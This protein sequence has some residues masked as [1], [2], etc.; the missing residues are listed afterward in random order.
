MN[1]QFSLLVKPASY[2]CNLRCAYCFYL[3]K[4]SMFGSGALR[5]PRDTLRTLTR[6]YLACPMADHSFGWQGGEPTLMGLDFFREAVRL[7]REFLPDRFTSNSLQTNGTLLDDEWAVFLKENR[8]LT[9]ISIDGPRELH[10]RF[11]RD[12]SGAGTHERVLRGRAALE[13]AGAEYNV[14]TLVSA[15]NQDYPAEVYEYLKS[16]GVRY[17]QYIE[18]VEFDAAGKRAPF[19]LGP[20][21]WGEFLCGIF[22]AW[23]PK[24]VGKVS[25]RLFDSVVSRLVSGVPTM[26]SMGADCRHYLVVEHNG[27]IF[28]CDFFVRSDL[29]LGNILK[30]DFEQLRGSAGYRDWGGI[31]RPQTPE[32]FGCAWYA[33]CAGDCPKNRCGGM[34]ALCEDWKI[35]YSHTIERFERLA[36]Y[37]SGLSASGVGRG[38]REKPGRNDPCPCGSG[39]KYKNCCGAV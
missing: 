14:L 24:D 32:C 17:H 10:D 28:P 15:A 2:N 4:E 38:S 30:D 7:Q 11:R 35:F 34:S 5:M 20:G 3:S 16:L 18:C 9:G 13:N 23:Y 6:K 19:A 36:G 37:V 22:D 33:L 21:K 29:R 25:V 1:G 39:K 27:D 8:F 26:C 12:S 31:K